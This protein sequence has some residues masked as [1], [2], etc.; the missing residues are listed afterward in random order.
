MDTV[1]VGEGH[2]EVRGHGPSVHVDVCEDRVE[3]RQ[4]VFTTLE[5]R[6]HHLHVHIVPFNSRPNK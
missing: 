6:V 3:L 1:H 5:V 4:L 2:V